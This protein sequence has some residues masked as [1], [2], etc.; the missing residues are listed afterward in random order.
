MHNN[1]CRSSHEGSSTALVVM[2]TNFE[3]NVTDLQLRNLAEHIPP[4]KS[5]DLGLNLG[6]TR[7]DMEEMFGGKAIQPSEKTFQILAR[8]RTNLDPVLVRWRNKVERR[9][10][11]RV[12]LEKAMQQS[13][14][15]DC[16]PCI[17]SQVTRKENESGDAKPTVNLSLPYGAKDADRKQE[18]EIRAIFSGDGGDLLQR[19]HNHLCGLLLNPTKPYQNWSR[20]RDLR[21]VFEHFGNLS[22]IEVFPICFMVDVVSLAN[23]N[24]LK[25]RIENGQLA[26]ALLG[27]LVADLEGND[28]QKLRLTMELDTE[29]YAN[30]ER[31]FIDLDPSLSLSDLNPVATGQD[32]AESST[33]NFNAW[34]TPRPET[35]LVDGHQH[36]VNL[37]WRN[38]SKQ[39]FGF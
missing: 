13:G 3:I 2:E 9:Q 25:E 31:F 32:A 30:G 10:T 33:E 8:W 12:K 34:K 1:V 26:E 14:L 16:I 23:L 22:N 37:V 35:A 24:Q 6:L 7:T 19:V 11:E 28:H 18:I 27:V 21:T 39:Q 29:S 5:D 20:I 17:D 4:S 38:L 15:E 36:G